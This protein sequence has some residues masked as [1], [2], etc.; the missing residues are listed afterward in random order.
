[1]AKR[2][3]KTK[4]PIKCAQC[5]LEFSES[6]L[7]E[8]HKNKAFVFN[9]KVMCD[10]CLYKMGVNTSDVMTYEAFIHSQQPKKPQN[11]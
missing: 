9:G 5:D 1:M 7:S 2:A 11:I 4:E 3:K 6:E 8:E 10:E